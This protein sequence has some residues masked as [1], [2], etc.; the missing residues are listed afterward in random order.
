MMRRS[1][2]SVWYRCR[3]GSSLHHIGKERDCRI[4]SR[5]CQFSCS[6][7]M[8]TLDRT[9]SK[10]NSD[11]T[12]RKECTPR[13]IECCFKHPRN[14][15]HQVMWHGSQHHPSRI[16]P[17]GF[18][19]RLQRPAE[20]APTERGRWDAPSWN[21]IMAG[22]AHVVDASSSIRS[23]PFFAEGNDYPLSSYNKMTPPILVWTSATATWQHGA[24][25]H[26]TRM[27]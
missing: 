24:P 19:C 18:K 9:R 6:P 2:F 14:Q 20:T 11:G 1:I 27:T 12:T 26:H 16:K 23:H 13:T 3:N 15:Y 4:L 22:S 8:S 21:N 25:V 17:S 10:F 5:Q 7:F